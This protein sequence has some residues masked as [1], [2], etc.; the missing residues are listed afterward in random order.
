MGT[1]FPTLK[2]T[3]RLCDLFSELFAISF[4]LYTLFCLNEIIHK[5]SVYAGL[6]AILPLFLQRKRRNFLL[7]DTYFH[8]ISVYFGFVSHV[9]TSLP[10]NIFAV[11]GNK[12][13]PAAS[14]EVRVTILYI[15]VILIYTTHLYYMQ[16]GVSG[17]VKKI[18]IFL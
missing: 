16:Y 15:S 3:E 18:L 12:I 6:L 17:Y 10:F 11:T 9:R 2:D 4:S 1:E 7:S 13:K 5:P 14:F 8:L